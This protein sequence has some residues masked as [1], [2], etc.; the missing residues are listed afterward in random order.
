MRLRLESLACFVG[1]K[2]R[3]S[4]TVDASQVLGRLEN[5]RSGVDLSRQEYVRK[6]TQI[7]MQRVIE[8]TPVD[9]GRARAGW[10]GGLGQME[11]DGQTT[12]ISVTND[13]EYII[14]LE[15]GTSRM[16]ARVMVRNSMSQTRDDVGSIPLNIFG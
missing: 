15:F 5:A 13:V 12:K 6:L 8:R 11:D 16:Q 1:G 3:I 7:L 14:F 4:F 9:T 10:N 2:M